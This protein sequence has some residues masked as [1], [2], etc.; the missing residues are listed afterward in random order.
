[1]L[2]PIT[3]GLISLVVLVV[4]IALRMP[5]AYSMILVG[6][7]GTLIMNGPFTVLNQLKT[8]AYGQFSNYGLSVVPMFVLM[9]AIA[10]RTGLS[11]ALFRGANA[12]LGWA[13]GGTAMAASRPMVG[14]SS[15]R[16]PLAKIVWNSCSAP[17]AASSPW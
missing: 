7:V 3:L 8:L 5:I 9:G 1:M 16:P 17:W 12:W 15:G 4:L 2:D 13:P 6:G 11:K 10:S 14:T